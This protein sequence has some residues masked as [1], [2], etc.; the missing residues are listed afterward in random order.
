MGISCSGFLMYLGLDR[1]YDIPHHNIIFSA[2]Y[3]KNVS[4][5][6]ETLERSA[7]PSIYVQNASPRDPSL[8]PQGCSA[9]YVLV[10]AP[11]CRSGLDWRVHKAEYRERVLDILEKKAGL[12]G[13][14]QHIVQELILTPDDFEREK[15][16]YRGAV[17]NLAHTVD[18]ML[19]MRPHNAFEEFDHCYLTGG[20]THPGSGLPTIVQ[21]GLISADLI[22][23]KA[24]R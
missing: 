24:G 6:T 20:G 15:L 3:R 17:F 19:W 12:G 10:P 23:A 1:I 13:L 4:E 16:V 22:Q 8:A 11:N 5:I 9:L 7:D 2:D 18:Q 14:R 21:S